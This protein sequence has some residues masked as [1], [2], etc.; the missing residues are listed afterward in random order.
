MNLKSNFMQKS[1]IMEAGHIKVCDVHFHK[2][3]D[4]EYDVQLTR[5]SGDIED[6]PEHIRSFVNPQS[7]KQYSIHTTE[8]LYCKSPYEAEQII[9]ELFGDGFYFTV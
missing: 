9:Y 1:L 7:P 5:Y 8:S 3:G 6:L 2:V 4:E